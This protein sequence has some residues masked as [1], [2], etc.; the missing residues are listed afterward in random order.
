[1]YKVSHK[2]EVGGGILECR[3]QTYFP[4]SVQFHVRPFT[5]VKHESLKD[6]KFHL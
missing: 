6:Q 5:Q 3:V 1:M 2:E 4:V